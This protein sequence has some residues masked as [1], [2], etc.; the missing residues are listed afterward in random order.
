ML[1]LAM[2]LGLVS[3]A[4]SGKMDSLRKW[5]RVAANG[6]EIVLYLD[7]DYVQAEDDD[8]CSPDPIPESSR[9]MAT[10]PQQEVV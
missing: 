5:G 9:S 1:I 8:I 10:P 3:G 4:T 2:M 7:D 6:G